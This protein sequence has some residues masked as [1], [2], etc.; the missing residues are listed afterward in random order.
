MQSDSAPPIEPD[1]LYETV[2]AIQGTAADNPSIWTVTKEVLESVLDLGP[3]EDIHTKDAYKLDILSWLIELVLTTNTIRE[4]I[5]QGMAQEKKNHQAT[6][7]EV[8]RLK[9]G[10][11]PPPPQHDTLSLLPAPC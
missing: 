5:D 4:Q 3:M 7:D 1:L 8:K 6:L 10:V 2:M 11:T 9:A